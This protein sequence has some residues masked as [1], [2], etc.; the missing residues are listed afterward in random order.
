MIQYLKTR[1]VPINWAVDTAK[2]VVQFEKANSGTKIL[3]IW[4]KQSSLSVVIIADF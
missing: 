3:H 2:L 4:I 1:C